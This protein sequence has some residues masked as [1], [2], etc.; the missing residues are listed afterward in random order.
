MEVAAMANEERK[1]RQ[2]QQQQERLHKQLTK[3]LFEVR[4]EADE[5]LTT[6][7]ELTGRK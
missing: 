7:V 2:K 6:W 3:H 5:P 4:E 1:Q